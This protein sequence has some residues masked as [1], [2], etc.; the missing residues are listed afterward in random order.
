MKGD[1]KASG[2]RVGVGGAKMEGKMKVK[3]EI[4]VDWDR[5]RER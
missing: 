2:N 3:E 4:K 1:G 5:V